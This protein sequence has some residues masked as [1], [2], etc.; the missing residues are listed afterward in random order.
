MSFS[1]KVT[2]NSTSYT[3]PTEWR[4]NLFLKD[5]NLGLDHEENVSESS[6]L[7]EFSK[8]DINSEQRDGPNLLPYEELQ[9]DGEIACGRKSLD[10]VPSS[11]SNLS[12]KIDSA[13]TGT[14]QQLSL[15]AQ[16]TL[17]TDGPQDISS[18]HKN[19]ADNPS[20]RRL[21]SPI[22]SREAQNLDLSLHFTPSF[23][24]PASLRVDGARLLLPE[25]GQIVVVVYD[26][27]PASIISYAISPKEYED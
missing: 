10:N 7:K 20:F 24:S 2:H 15:K 11:S 1:S 13:W 16:F 17:Q 3:E 8:Y 25:T 4:S 21:S 27:E 18:R 6:R 12:D 19:Q 23:T 5:V 22:S 9:S 26:N 14:D